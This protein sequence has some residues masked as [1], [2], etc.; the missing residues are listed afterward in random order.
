MSCLICSEDCNHLADVKKAT[1]DLE[2]FQGY[3][4]ENITCTICHSLILEPM[5]M[6]NGHLIDRGCLLECLRTPGGY[7][8]QRPVKIAIPSVFA[9]DEIN[10]LLNITY[11][12][13]IVMPPIG[14]VIHTPK[15]VPERVAFMESF[16]QVLERRRYS[17]SEI[18][19][20]AGPV[21]LRVDVLEEVA[22]IVEVVPIRARD[23]SWRAARLVPRNQEVNLELPQT[24]GRI[25][26][27]TL[28]YPVRE[29]ATPRRFYR[30]FLNQ[31]DTSS[32][33]S[34]TFDSPVHT[35]FASPITHL[36]PETLFDSDATVDLTEDGSVDMD[37]INQA[38]I[39]QMMYRN[40]ET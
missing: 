29:G 26:Q 40:R 13:Q 37:T 25:Q 36:T 34:A 30:T 19:D 17:P 18:L 15:Y 6:D 4:Y 32:L 8:P 11:G 28:Q 24:P 33:D 10:R 1:K 35:S 38:Q 27:V 22:D 21:G 31:N 39:F 12:R 20:Q 2:G 23:A 16:N 14:D 7:D 5:V 3:A 9:R